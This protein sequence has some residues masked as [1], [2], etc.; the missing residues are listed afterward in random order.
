MTQAETNAA[1]GGDVPSIVNTSLQKSKT[2]QR[3][4]WWP[5]RSCDAKKYVGW[6]SRASAA[7]YRLLSEAEWEYAARAGTTTGYFWGDDVGSGNANCNGCGSRWDDKKT[8]PVGSF[9]A[10][11]FGLHDM[12]GNVWEWV[13]D[14]WNDSYAGAPSDGGAWT[15]GDCDRRVL[16]GGSWY[17]DPRDVLSAHRDGHWTDDRDGNGGFRVARTLTP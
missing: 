10:N 15:T 14:C 17:E 8:A 5:S 13:D 4:R 7:E 16:R 3:C 6:L 9:A 11:G 1:I 2:S 12:L